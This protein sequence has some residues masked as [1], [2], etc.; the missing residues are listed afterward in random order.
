MRTLR[1]VHRTAD[2]LGQRR[3]LLALAAVLGC[4][5]LQFLGPATAMESENY[6]INWSVM[7]G[8]GEPIHS[9][10]FALN[11][12]LGQPSIGFKASTNYG[13]CSGYWCTGGYTVYLPVMLR[14]T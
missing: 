10:N 11:A 4:I 13:A 14:S 5:L 8:G 6:A 9:D 3:T 2:T 12:T 1:F 7:G